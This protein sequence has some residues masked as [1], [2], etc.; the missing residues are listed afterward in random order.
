[1]FATRHMKKKVVLRQDYKI[2]GMRT[3]YVLRHFTLLKQIRQ[4]ETQVY[5]NIGHQGTL[6]IQRF[7]PTFSSQISGL[8]ATANFLDTS[9]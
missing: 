1:M 5:L 2:Q 9:N 6:K 7:S 8:G 4:K 3:Q